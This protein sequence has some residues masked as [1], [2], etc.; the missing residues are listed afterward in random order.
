MG[1]SSNTCEYTPGRLVID[2]ICMI[3]TDNIISIN[4]QF[5]CCGITVRPARGYELWKR[6]N[7]HFRSESGPTVPESCCKSREDDPIRKACQGKQPRR[8]DTYYEVSFIHHQHRLNRQISMLTPYLY[9][10]STHQGLL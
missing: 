5:E 2:S 10:N 4:H 1:R 6:E 7:V 3:Q 8:E 9:P